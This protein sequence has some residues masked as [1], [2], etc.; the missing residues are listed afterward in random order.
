MQLITSK[1]YCQL[2]DVVANTLGAVFG[3]IILSIWKSVFYNENA[4]YIVQ[5]IQSYS[6][7][8]FF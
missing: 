7:K 4:L 6:S 8:E 1:G 2:D 5:P 3:M